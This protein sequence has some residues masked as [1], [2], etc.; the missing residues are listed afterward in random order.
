MNIGGKR[1]SPAAQI[2]T[3][4]ILILVLLAATYAIGYASGRDNAVQAQL[5]HP[6]CNANLKP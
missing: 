4:R 2:M 3:N 5:N 1:S 6:A